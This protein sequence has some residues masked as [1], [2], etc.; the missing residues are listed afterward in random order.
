LA[1]AATRH[2]PIH[3]PGLQPVAALFS[4]ARW[5]LA[6][7]HARRCASSASSAPRAV[8][9]A[10]D[11]RFRYVLSALMTAASP[12]ICL[13]LHEDHPQRAVL[14]MSPRRLAAI[15]EF[16]TRQA[17]R[18]ATVVHRHCVSSRGR[19]SGA[20]YSANAVDA[21]E[22]GSARRTGVTWLDQPH[23]GGACAPSEAPRG[24]PR[25][26]SPSQS[27]KGKG[28]DIGTRARRGLNGA[29]AEC[30]ALDRTRVAKSNHVI[31]AWRHC[32]R[33]S[34]RCPGSFAKLRPTPSPGYNRHPGQSAHHAFSRCV[35][36]IAR[37]GQRTTS[38]SGQ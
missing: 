15:K 35:W 14:F 6:R 27:A 20:H 28:D 7:L 2:P 26:G 16:W 1:G 32:R 31:D 10:I 5:P 34:R 18:T 23:A 30:L 33:E 24:N 8:T 36:T 25:M 12:Q 13:V 19:S 21:R 29:R 4:S 11:I 22:T 37:G 9:C 17:D 3:R 38:A